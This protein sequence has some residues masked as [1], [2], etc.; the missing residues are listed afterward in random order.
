MKAH[1]YIFSGIIFTVLVW[2]SCIKPETQTSPNVDLTRRYCNNPYAS[3]YNDSF[4]GIPDSTRCRYPADDFSGS[5]GM[6]DSI[7]KTDSTFV[8]A[9]NVDL[10]FIPIDTEARNELNLNGWCSTGSIHVKANKYGRAV[11]VN[12][13][14]YPDSAQ[15]VCGGD[16]L[17]GYFQFKLNTKDTMVILANETKASGLVLFHKA[18]AFRK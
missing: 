14:E 16:T 13:L 1:F 5:W 8:E 18:I 7:F 12:K 11:V 6:N 9:R 4:P 2:V 10:N 17:M 15:V 3:N